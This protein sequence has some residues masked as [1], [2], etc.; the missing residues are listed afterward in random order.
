MRLSLILFALLVN[1][2]LAVAQHNVKKAS[3]PAAPSPHEV[4]RNI[5][6]VIQSQQKAWN[7]GSLE[8]F[9]SHYWNS[10]TLR[11]VSKNGVTYGWQKVYENYKNNYPDPASMGQ[12][13]FEIINVEL[14]NDNHAMVTGKW[15]LKVDK[16][17]KGGY[18]TLLFR[19]IK[20]RWMIVADHTS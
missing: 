15:L 11:F 12:L 7:E 10:D 3:L 16:K 17:F 18:F 9:M 6:S 13:E 8:A 2:S 14:I 5:I 19:K 4:K 20:D 1:Y